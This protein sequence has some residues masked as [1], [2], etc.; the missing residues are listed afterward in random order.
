MQFEFNDP[1]TITAVKGSK[2]NTINY[3]NYKHHRFAA[4]NNNSINNNKTGTLKLA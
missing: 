2:E 4:N 3:I 1:L